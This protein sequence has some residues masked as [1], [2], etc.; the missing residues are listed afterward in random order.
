[1]ASDFQRC[2]VAGVF[3]A[4]DADGDDALLRSDFVALAD[5]WTEVRGAAPGSADHERLTAI[6]LGWWSALVAASDLDHDGRITLD[7][8]MTLVGRLDDMP[9]AL[10]ATAEV[11]FEAIDE[12]ADG[13]ISSGEYRRLIE[14][15]NGRATDTDAVFPLLDSDGD[16][17]LSR[18]EFTR[19]WAEFWAGD[20]PEEPGTWVFGHFA[21][22][23]HRAR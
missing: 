7:E 21:L 17:H 20:D 3:E 4:M 8:V 5:R 12:N 10:T 1:M 19:L 15:W 18:E 14:V 13:R 2:K 11:M 22:P 6:M 23:L 9:E 16:G